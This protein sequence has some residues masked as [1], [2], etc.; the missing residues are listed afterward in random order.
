M[1]GYAVICQDMFITTAQC[2]LSEILI[3]SQYFLSD[4]VHARVCVCVW[5]RERERGRLSSS[6][7]IKSWKNV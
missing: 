3:Q 2:S 4:Y 1:P 6:K 7:W 5:E